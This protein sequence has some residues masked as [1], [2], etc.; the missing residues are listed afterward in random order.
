MHF[1]QIFFLSGIGGVNCLLGFFV[2]IFLVGGRG[3]IFFRGCGS[4]M[5]NI[6]DKGE[7]EGLT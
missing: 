6:A 1:D 5:L 2:Q 7:G 4:Q 3:Q